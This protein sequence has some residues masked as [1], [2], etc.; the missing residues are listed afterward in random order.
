[1]AAA[2]IEV[3]LFTHFVS[4]IDSPAAGSKRF[5]WVALFSPDVHG[6]ALTLRDC[7]HS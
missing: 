2:V 3:S 6:K 1:L 7:E 4:D 5:D